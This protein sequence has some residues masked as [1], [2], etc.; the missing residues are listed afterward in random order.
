M[1]SVVCCTLSVFITLK[2]LNT[3]QSRI[4]IQSVEIAARAKIS[5]QN[6]KDLC[7][8]SIVELKLKFPKE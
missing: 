8:S 7:F 3:F 2:V 1:Q 5:L 4:G 6:L